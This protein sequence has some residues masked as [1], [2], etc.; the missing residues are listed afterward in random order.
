MFVDEDD[1]PLAVELIHL[2][3]FAR[4]V[5]STP[6]AIVLVGDGGPSS[7]L[8][9]VAEHFAE[10][11]RHCGSFRLGYVH[12]P[13]APDWR[14]FAERNL[15]RVRVGRASAL[16]PDGY[17]LFSGGRPVAWH[18]GGAGAGGPTDELFAVVLGAMAAR[19]HDGRR[20]LE[21]MRAEAVIRH[22]E[23]VLDGDDDD[24]AVDGG[25]PEPTV[26]AL[27][28]DDPHAILGT[29]PGASFD[30]L[31]AAYLRQLT[32]NHPDKVAHM[33]DEIVRFATERTRRIAD[34]WQRILRLHRRSG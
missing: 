6:R 12:R 13:A 31:R 30:E 21:A 9:I 5:A 18:R 16:A 14:A 23:A 19:G 29:T 1:G 27:D 7:W 15:G 24:E 33:S 4:F 11:P 2:P 26:A 17:Y 34:A 28:P 20:R 3:G 8:A 10:E 22:F 32:L 25:R